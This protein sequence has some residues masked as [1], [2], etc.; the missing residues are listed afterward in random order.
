MAIMRPAGDFDRTYKHDMVVLRQ[1]W[2]YVLLILFI[3]ALFALP[4]YASESTVSLI[5]RIGIFIIAVQGLNIKWR[6]DTEGLEKCRQ[7]GREIAERM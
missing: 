7:M 1:R 5:N 2:Q 6:P 4:Y 3:V